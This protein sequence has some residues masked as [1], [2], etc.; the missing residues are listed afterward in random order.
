MSAASP[1]ITAGVT[2]ALY[3]ALLGSV[4]GVGR[5]AAARLMGGDPRPAAQEDNDDALVWARSLADDAAMLDVLSGL[6][7]FKDRAP[8]AFDA[9]VMN[10]DALVELWQ[11]VAPGDEPRA[12]HPRTAAAHIAAARRALADLRDAAD[13]DSSDFDDFASAL[14]KQLADYQ[15]NI[16]LSTMLYLPNHR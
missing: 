10:C 7:T 15:H 14:Q 1:Y 13:A 16:S 11:R 8:G 12:L 6:R 2:T 5:A 3:G 9:L 4:L